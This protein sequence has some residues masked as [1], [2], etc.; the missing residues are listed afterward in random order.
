MQNWLV[1]IIRCSD[2][3]LYTGITTDLERRFAEHLLGGK[4]AKYF[5]RCRP[6][7]IVYTEAGLNRSE[8]ARR[9]ARIKALSHKE[10]LELIS[11]M[12]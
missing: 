2:G 10:K 12:R 5:R 8:A 9:E 11:R 4:G 6:L 3:S 7:G 1:Y